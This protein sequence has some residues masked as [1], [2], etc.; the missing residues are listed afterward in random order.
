MLQTRQLDN[1]VP[2]G[3]PKTSGT[4][5]AP[6]SRS[7]TLTS[8]VHAPPSTTARSFYGGASSSG[9]LTPK[10]KPPS[11][12]GP[13]GKSCIGNP[14]PKPPAK[15]TSRSVNEANDDDG[16]TDFPYQAPITG[17]KAYQPHAVSG[18]TSA[19]TDGLGRAPPEPK[20]LFNPDAEGAVVMARPPDDHIERN[21]KKNLPIVDVVLDP[22]IA[23]KLRPHQIEGVKFMYEC[24]MGY[25]GEGQ[26]CI[27]A[28]DMGLGKTIQSIALILTLLKQTPYYNPRSREKV[29]SR[30]LI[31]C[32]V[33]LVQNWSREFQ[34]WV[35]KDKVGVFVVGSKSNI[36]DF[37]RNKNFSVIIIGYEKVSRSANRVVDLCSIKR[38]R[39]I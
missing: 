24:V 25:R 23:K 26:G 6:V 8:N 37:G 16:N 30:A 19:A 20:A 4:F 10:F 27:L 17:N 12:V 39:H 21:N 29:I 34:K 7:S 1:L 22:Q 15:T 31:A 2:N 33:T 14:P 5:A 18:L 32:P 38:Q 11:R 35:G 36:L 13:F 9:K 3:P 28:D